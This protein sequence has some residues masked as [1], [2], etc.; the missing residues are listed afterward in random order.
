VLAAAASPMLVPDDVA[1]AADIDIGHHDDVASVAPVAAIRPAARNA[2][3]TA[4][5]HAP[6]TPVSGQAVNRDSVDK[7][8]SIM[9]EAPATA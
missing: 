8:G 1:Q 4:E 3:L 6:R 5:A 2:S 9:A 7:H